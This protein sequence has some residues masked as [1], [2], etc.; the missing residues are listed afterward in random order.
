[1]K[2]EQGAALV[3]LLYILL[4]FS[5][6]GASLL[7]LAVINFRVSGH[8][9]AAEQAQYAA[10]AGIDLAEAVL[11]SLWQQNLST[12]WQYEH[13]E[14]PAFSVSVSWQEGVFKIISQGRAKHLTQSAE[15]LAYVQ[16]VGRQALYTNR[17][18]L[19]GMEIQGHLNAKELVF[20]Q[21]ESLI[22]GDL[23]TNLLTVEEGAAYNCTG[24]IHAVIKPYDL[25]I[26]FAEL[27]EK[28]YFYDWHIPDLVDGFCLIDGLQT[29][30]IYAPVSAKISLKAP[31][32]GLIVAAKDVFINEWAS[33]SQVVIVAAGDVILDNAVGFWPGSLFIYSAGSISRHNAARLQINGCLLSPLLQLQNISI[34]YNDLAILRQ[35]SAVPRELLLADPSFTLEWLEVSPRR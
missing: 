15:V 3:W 9:V 18:E 31:W 30:P 27:Q 23:R 29:G 1:M 12:E 6:L 8:L 22:T 4:L 34:T 25:N 28:A 7:K 10:E 24:N 16:P 33:D 11:P 5:L 2:N 14:D 13:A 26:N 32:E 21:G 35:Q 17:A 20:T 19:A